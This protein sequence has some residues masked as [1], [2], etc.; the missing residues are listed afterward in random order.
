[1]ISYYHK[2]T[3]GHCETWAL[4]VGSKYLHCDLTRKL[5][6]LEKCCNQRLQSLLNL[7]LITV[8]NAI[9]KQHCQDIRVNR[10]VDM[11]PA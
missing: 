8:H 1:M 2:V 11:G 6:V 7:N 9:E 4:T 5:F 10:H 3:C